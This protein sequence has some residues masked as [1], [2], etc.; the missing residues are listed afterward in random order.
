M[1]HNICRREASNKYLKGKP[2]QEVQNE[3][4]EKGLTKPI[5]KEI[6]KKEF[7]KRNLISKLGKQGDIRNADQDTE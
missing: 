1:W 7:G 3:K 2:E 4:C 6:M 5:G